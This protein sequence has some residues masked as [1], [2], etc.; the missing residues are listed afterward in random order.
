MTAQFEEGTEGPEAEPR[1]GVFL[2]CGWSLALLP[3]SMGPAG[4]S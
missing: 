3:G 1:G 4:D 2:L